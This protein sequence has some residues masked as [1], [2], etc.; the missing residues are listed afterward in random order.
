MFDIFYAP[1]QNRA[2]GGGNVVFPCA[3]SPSNGMNVSVFASNMREA[4]RKCRKRAEALNAQLGTNITCGA[5][6]PM[7]PNN[8]RR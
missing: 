3:C 4:S 8:N 7:N 1:R 2:V 6:N 5:F